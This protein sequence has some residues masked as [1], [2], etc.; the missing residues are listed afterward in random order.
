MYV[1]RS[2]SLLVVICLC[3]AGCSGPPNPPV[4]AEGVVTFAPSITEVT[5]ALGQG[6]R[7]IGVS[8]FCNYPPE[9][10]QIEEVGGWL[11]PNLEKLTRLAPEMIIIQGEH[12]KVTE[13]AS[14]SGAKLVRVDM[15]SL[16]TIAEGIR[17]IGAVLQC[18]D[19]AEKLVSDMEGELDAVRKAVAGRPRPKVL[20][21][22]GRQLH[23]MDSLYTVGGPSFLSELV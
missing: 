17:T 21:L 13:F 6:H 12:E 3:A 14:H 10:D 20:L 7:V 9:T 16:A 22:T 2:L 18:E 4:K 8:E 23:V 5:F 11:N 19:A 1:S 15:D